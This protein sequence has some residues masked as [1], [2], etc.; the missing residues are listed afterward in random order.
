[1]SIDFD[2]EFDRRYTERRERERREEEER[3]ERERDRAELATLRERLEK[4]EKG[5]K[6]GPDDH[7]PEV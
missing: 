1:M 2:R 7:E 6:P 4:I 3:A 5:G